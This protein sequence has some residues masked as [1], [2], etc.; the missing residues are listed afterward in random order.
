[1]ASEKN[2]LIKLLF[3]YVY[4]QK[5]HSSHVNIILTFGNIIPKLHN[6]HFLKLFFSVIL[7]TRR[8]AKK[9]FL[10]NVRCAYWLKFLSIYNLF[11]FYQI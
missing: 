1:M 3:F 4:C 11:S 9:Y 7:R 10:F 6:V 5:L 8:Y 2:K